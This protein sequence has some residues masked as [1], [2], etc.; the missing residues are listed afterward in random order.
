MSHC[1]L[2]TVNSKLRGI[3]DLKHYRCNR[4]GD[5]ESYS[6]YSAFAHLVIDRLIVENTVHRAGRYSEFMTTYVYS[7]Q[8]LI[9]VLTLVLELIHNQFVPAASV[10]GQKKVKPCSG[11]CHRIPTLDRPPVVC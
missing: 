1:V 8:I 9:T 2:L 5:L 3:V 4:V 10:P 6:M 11:L 7:I